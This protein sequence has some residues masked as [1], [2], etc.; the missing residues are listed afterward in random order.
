MSLKQMQ[1]TR[2]PEAPTGAADSSKTTTAA[3]PPSAGP[4]WVLVTRWALIGLTLVVLGIAAKKLIEQGA[5]I[6]VVIVA[7]LAMCVVVIYGTRRA[8]P[9]KYLLAGLVLLVGLQIWPIAYTVATSLTNY[10]DGHAMSMTKSI[11]SI[12]ANSVR[13]VPNTP[14]Y[15]LSVAVRAGSDPATGPVF[16]PLTDP[17]GKT[18]VG[19]KSGLSALAGAEAGTAADGR[20]MRAAGYQI[21]TAIQVNARQDLGAFAV[22]TKAG[23]GIKADK[24]GVRG[25]GKRVL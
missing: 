23:A 6:G 8:V 14:R 18:F 16:Y 9:M 12:I 15:R 1:D 24:R 2:G 3:R 5:W 17:A 4:V 20:I 11:D 25:R 22:P 10:G 7:F 21:L 13:E 19:D